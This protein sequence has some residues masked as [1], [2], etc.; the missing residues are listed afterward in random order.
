MIKERLKKLFKIIPVITRDQLIKYYFL[1]YA[2]PRIKCTL[3]VQQL[4]KEGILTVNKTYRPFI[5][6][7]QTI[8]IPQQSS[9]LSHHI[10]VVDFYLRN[11]YSNFVYEPFLGYQ[12]DGFPR[13]DC[14][15]EYWQKPYFVEVQTERKHWTEKEVRLKLD[16][17][18]KAYIHSTYKEYTDTFPTILFVGGKNYKID[19]DIKFK[20]QPN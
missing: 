12:K 3:T 16:R 15:I 1:D 2:N 14:Y 6:F 7:S 13:P 20:W 9:K 17:Y 8:K 18:R 19:H 4:A 10:D 11:N 5:C